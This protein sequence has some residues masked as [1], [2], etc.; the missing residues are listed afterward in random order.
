MFA[1]THPLDGTFSQK[2]LQILFFYRQVSR[3]AY[4][5]SFLV[6]VR[7]TSL[8][9]WICCSTITDYIIHR[10]ISL[11]SSYLQCSLAFQTSPPRIKHCSHSSN[12]TNPRPEVALLCSALLEPSLGFYGSGVGSGHYAI[13]GGRGHVICRPLQCST[14]SATGVHLLPALPMLYKLPRHWSYFLFNQSF[15]SIWIT[16]MSF[17]CWYFLQQKRV[18]LDAPFLRDIRAWLGVGNIEISE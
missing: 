11:Q 9:Q 8:K 17:P 15:S 16:S 3:L 1:R 14:V 10:P 13:H 2:F 18:H 6:A 5:L 4:Q 7:E 12:L